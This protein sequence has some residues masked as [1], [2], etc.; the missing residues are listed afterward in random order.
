MC[1]LRCPSAQPCRNVCEVP[2]CEW[3]CRAPEVCPEPTCH[4]V[5]EAPPSCQ[6][7]TY[8]QLPPLSPGEMSVRSFAAPADGGGYIDG[9]VQD[10]GPN[11][12]AQRPVQI[13]PSNAGYVPPQFA[14]TSQPQPVPSYPLLDA[15]AVPSL[16]NIPESFGTGVANPD[17]WEEYMDRFAPH[18]D[19]EH[20]QPD[21]QTV[22]AV[23]RIPDVQAG[24]EEIPAEAGLVSD[25]LEAAQGIEASL[26]RDPGSFSRALLAD[27]EFANALQLNGPQP[28][29]ALPSEADEMS[30]RLRTVSFPVIPSQGRQ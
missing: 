3:H 5:C 15:S 20:G 1:K 24:Q 13:P 10:Y 28:S 8:Q 14:P 26:L 11:F 30:L 4:M 9:S 22:Q 25:Q 7:N 21:E 12:A 27:A 18:H 23:E 19:P 29:A 2:S 17:R 16:P 6:G